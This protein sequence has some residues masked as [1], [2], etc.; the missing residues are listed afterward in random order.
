MW[1]DDAA[2]G[3][4]RCTF[5]RCVW[6]TMITRAELLPQHSDAILR[7]FGLNDSHHRAVYVTISR[8]GPQWTTVIHS[9]ILSTRVRI[10]VRSGTP[11]EL[12]P[13]AFY[14]AGS[15]PDCACL[16]NMI[17]DISETIDRQFLKGLWTIAHQNDL[18][19]GLDSTLEHLLEHIPWMQLASVGCSVGSASITL[20]DQ[21]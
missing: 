14:T 9:L 2:F 12:V 8:A 1:W 3:V 18:D 6:R 4:V 16:D 11:H 10:G 21:W 17:F 15:W 19:Y 20:R 7:M 13:H 5:D